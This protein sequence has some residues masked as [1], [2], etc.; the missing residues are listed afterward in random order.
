M[1]LGVNSIRVIRI[2]LKK[3]DRK[4][5][6]NW[7]DLSKYEIKKNIDALGDGRYDHEIDIVYGDRQNKKGVT[8]I[9]IHGGSYIYSYRNN[10]Y[11]FATVFADAGFD[12]VLLDY[13]HNDECKDSL[14]Q[15]NV[16]AKQLE[17]VF[18]HGA[19]LGLNPDRVFL[20]GDSAGGHFALLL[21][22]AIKDLELRRDLNISFEGVKLAG[23]AVN[24]PVYDYLRVS[25]TTFISK[26]G[27]KFLFGKRYD[28][29]DYLRALSPKCHIKS[30]DIPVFVS[31]CQNDFLI[32]ETRDLVRDLTELQKAPTY[33]FID[34]EDRAVAHVH[35][36]VNIN[37]PDSVFVN[38]EMI[39]FFSSFNE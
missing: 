6:L 29:A 34:K 5:H 33:C 22:E 17:Y 23:L 27:R 32:Q 16:L 10:N 30:L 8:L 2:H 14:V 12:V 25:Q 13:P 15:V 1:K 9:D 21:T 18:S 31:S 24:C 39:K 36:V 35:N 26:R 37:H 4:R 20:T 11:G 3:G 38:Q 19:E 7:S 28:D